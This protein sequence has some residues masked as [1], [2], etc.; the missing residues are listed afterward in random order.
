MLA[1]M[2]PLILALTLIL[3]TPGS[4]LPPPPPDGIVDVV[5]PHVV[6][7]ERLTASIQPIP[8]V[9]PLPPPAAPVVFTGPNVVANCGD[10]FY[11]N[12]IYTNESSCDTNKY[13]SIGCYGIGQ[14][15]PASKIGH[16]GMDYACQNAWFTNYANERY[17]GWA[18]AY[19]AWNSQYDA[20]GNHWW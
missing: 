3:L 8:E 5:A 16:C 19:A 13:N 14:S 4:T 11:A 20:V 18:G 9:V 2:K 15:C 6:P 1:P 17:G 10:N 12:Y 7:F